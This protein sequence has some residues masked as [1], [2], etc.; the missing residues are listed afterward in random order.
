MPNVHRSSGSLR[1][2]LDR[3]GPDVGIDESLLCQ[4]DALAFCLRRLREA[5]GALRPLTASAPRAGGGTG[6]D[7]RREHGG[8]CDGFRDRGDEDGISRDGILAL[9]FGG[10]EEGGL[11]EVVARMGVSEAA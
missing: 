9:V 4:R 7:G 3:L 6:R 11:G 5:V 1:L 2:R 10:F 8:G